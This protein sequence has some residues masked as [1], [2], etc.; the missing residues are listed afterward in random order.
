[1]TAQTVRLIAQQGGM[2]GPLGQQIITSLPHGTNLAG[3]PIM[4]TSAGGG[5]QLITTANSAQQH[6][7][8]QQHLQQQHQNALNQA[9]LATSLAQ[10]QQLGP[11]GQM[12]LSSAT[13]LPQSRMTVP[14]M[15]QTFGAGGLQQMGVGTALNPQVAMNQCQ[16]HPGAPLRQQLTPS[17]SPPVRATTPSKAKAPS[18]SKAREKA[19]ARRNAAA[20]LA[21]AAASANSAGTSSSGPS[22]GLVGPGAAGPGE[23]SGTTSRFRDDDDI[24]D[25]AAMGGV[26]LQEESQRI[27]GTGAEIIGQQIRSCKD[28]PFLHGTPLHTRINTICKWHLQCVPLS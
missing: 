3:T 18:K 15:V 28:D 14:Q 7:V 11:G 9:Q 19:E 16:L 17:P 20:A 25:V 22:F 5:T 6:Q 4:L 23:K 1:M 27:L 21:A 24:N 2:G 8:H 12:Q 26:N 10:Q 13:T